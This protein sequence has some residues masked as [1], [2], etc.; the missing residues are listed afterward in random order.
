MLWLPLRAHSLFVL[1]D[2]LWLISPASPSLTASPPLTACGPR[3]AQRVPRYVLLL[4]E[5]VKHTPPALEEELAEL[6]KL[7][8]TIRAACDAID[9][10]VAGGKA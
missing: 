1:L 9:A 3:C 8:E 4:G 2:S 5:L 10:A 7:Q 6:R